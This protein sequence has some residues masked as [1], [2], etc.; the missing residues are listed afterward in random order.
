[1]RQSLVL[2][3]ALGCV[4]YSEAIELEVEMDIPDIMTCDDPNGDCPMP[5]CVHGGNCDRIDHA[6]EEE[7]DSCILDQLLGECEDCVAKTV[8]NS[9]RPT[10]QIIQGTARAIALSSLRTEVQGATTAPSNL[11]RNWKR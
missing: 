6:K 8:G 2:A 11:I 7:C 1:M 5:G 3:L 10:S 9:G 4:P